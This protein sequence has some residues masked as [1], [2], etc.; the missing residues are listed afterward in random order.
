MSTEVSSISDHIDTGFVKPVFTNAEVPLNDKLNRIGGYIKDSTDTIQLAVGNTY[1]RNIANL[2]AIIGNAELLTQDISNPDTPIAQSPNIFD[3]TNQLLNRLPVVVTETTVSPFRLVID[4][5]IS[6]SAH[7]PQIT[8]PDV[9]NLAIATTDTNGQIIKVYD[10]SFTTRAG[11][12]G[13]AFVSE[14]DFITSDSDFDYLDTRLVLLT[15]NRSIIQELVQA[16]INVGDLEYSSA[17]GYI[18]GATDTIQTR[19]GSTIS[20]SDEINFIEDK[21]FAIK[22]RARLKKVQAEPI[23]SDLVWTIGDWETDSSPSTALAQDYITTLGGTIASPS[24][25]TVYA[26]S[27]GV[28]IVTSANLPSAPIVTGG[29]DITI[30]IPSTDLTNISTEAIDVYFPVNIPYR[31]LRSMDLAYVGE[32][33]QLHEMFGKVIGNQYGYGTLSIPG[34]IADRLDTLE[35]QR[36]ILEANIAAIS[37]VVV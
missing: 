22:W 13:E 8:G 14:I 27:Q 17:L 1:L 9:I 32:G 6:K 7:I 10:G 37:G 21:T 3:S 34:T 2:A 5:L 24:G 30:S 11:Y 28:P 25:L 19:T 18:P 12:S 35:T 16:I 33:S 26:Y 29:N 23:G 20:I 36:T 15:A 4:G 31:L